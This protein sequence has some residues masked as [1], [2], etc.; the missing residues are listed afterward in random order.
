MAGPME[1][2]RE[3]QMLGQAGDLIYRD[4][5]EF[6]HK[7]KVEQDR[8][9]TLRAEDAFTRLREKQLELTAGEKGF[10][11]VKGVDAISKPLLNDYT[12]QFSDNVQQIADGLGN[13]QQKEKFRARAGVAGLAFREDILRHLISE[14]KSAETQ[15][16]NGM[17]AVE[18]KQVTAN[19]DKS[20]AVGLSIARIKDGIATQA[21]SNGW[22]TEY[23]EAREKEILGKV[24]DSVI[25]LA[26]SKGNLVYAKEWFEANKADVDVGTAK[27]LQA[28]VVDADQRQRYNGYQSGYLAV[29]ESIPGLKALQ[30]AVSED[31]ALDEARK[32]TLIGR[33]QSQTQG[34][35]RRAEAAA[36]RAD[37]RMTTELNAL[38]TRIGQGWEPGLEQMGQLMEMG[39]GRPQVQA[40]VS[41]VIGTANATRAF[42]TA[43][44]VS[45]ERMI[46]Q[47]TLG[48][49]DGTVEPKLLSTFKTIAEAQ[50]T[51]RN[52]DPTSF[53]VRQGLVSPTE[54]AGKPM[55]MSTPNKVVPNQMQ[56]RLDLARAMAGQ[57]KTPFKPLTEAERQLAVATLRNANGDGKRQYFKE[58][59]L[60]T[61]DDF[62]GYK[63]I[64]AQI[65]PDD[66][67]T[68]AA[69]LFA[70][71]GERDPKAAKAAEL[72]ID[73]Q[74][75]L[76]PNKGADGKPLGGALLTMPP[77]KDMRLRFDDVVREAYA[78]SPEA[79]N[80]TY[81]TAEAIYASLS[82][83]AGDRDTGVLDSKRWDQAIEMATGGI[84][85]YAKKHVVKPWGMPDS[86]FFDQVD[87]RLRMQL[88][89]KA[90]DPNMSLGRLR[91]MPLRAIGDGR[92]TLM[93]GDAVL[94][95]TKGKPVVIDFNQTIPPE[96]VR[97]SPKQPDLA[98]GA[99]AR[100]NPPRLGKVL[101]E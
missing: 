21:E 55:D 61:G 83:Q 58:L 17:V 6:E 70:R 94:T 67:V 95:D 87:A 46:T 1:T 18:L 36:E 63:A 16:F 31:P 10:S 34:L 39:R 40:L 60:S 49:R 85:Q 65:A 32:N 91:D 82:R 78:S 77:N 22:P 37:R 72:M 99:A 86:T 5:K 90:L 98:R 23:K 35:E 30:E 75:I 93:A 20:Q 14:N 33:I 25:D 68:A 38:M 74:S 88:E 19:W 81:Q 13:D 28:K 7:V 89:S 44:P 56:S 101:Q 53:A 71:R 8:A 4:Q 27:T 54:L 96:A 64:L 15:Q 42:R 9:D 12:K 84:T 92:Y 80:A 11:R 47:A 62:E 26:I 51:E 52:N 43:D 69:G 48:V 97:K 100:D 59:S 73:G 29:Q 3:G 76:R 50:T 41:Q 24:H 2:I 66:P 79:R 57:Y 45:Q